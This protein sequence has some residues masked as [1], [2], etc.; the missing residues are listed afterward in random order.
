M[1]RSI[2]LLQPSGEVHYAELS[3]PMA[4]A[5]SKDQINHVKKPP[6]P[7]YTYYEEPT[8]YAQI[9]HSKTFQ[10]QHPQAPSVSS[11]T[12]A[13][14]MPHSS[15]HHQLPAPSLSHQQMQ[16]SPVVGGAATAAM[17]Q[18][19]SHLHQQQHSPHVV[20]SMAAQTTMLPPG[21]VTTVVVGAANSPFPPVIA[22][23]AATSPMS[24]QQYH[25]QQQLH[26]QTM[27]LQ[28]N[29]HSTMVTATQGTTMYPAGGAPGSG[30]GTAP[31]P[32]P[33]NL[34]NNKQYLREIVTVRTPVAFSQQESCV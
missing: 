34:S 19:P 18:H 31:P 23:T 1:N 13:A 5:T 24:Q 12:M 9:D 22:A 6:P 17:V 11:R 29:P 7:A 16:Q 32:H 4:R 27:M 2:V 10:Q 30:L 33:N 21:A 8:I 28:H 25:Q 14:T 15:S 3:L 26:H 20:Y